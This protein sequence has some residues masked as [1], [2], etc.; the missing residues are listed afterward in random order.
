MHDAAVQDGRV[1]FDV[2]TDHLDAV[3]RHLTGFG[4][5]SLRSAPPTLEELFLRHYG[6]ELAEDGV[7]LATTGRP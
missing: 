2:D 3:L 1:R 5:R 7:P 4:V 6:D